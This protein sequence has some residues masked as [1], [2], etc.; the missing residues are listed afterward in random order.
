[1][2]SYDISC[3]LGRCTFFGPSL[4]SPA[5]SSEWHLY[6]L[7]RLASNDPST[8][9]EQDG[10]GNAGADADANMPQPDQATVASAVTSTTAGAVPHQPAVTPPTAFTDMESTNPNTNTLQPGRV[11]VASAVTSMA[12]GAV[13]RQPIIT[14]PAASVDMMPTLVSV[15]PLQPAVTP[16]V[17]LAK[18]NATGNSLPSLDPLP[19]NPR[20]TSLVGGSVGA[21][22]DTPVGMDQD[23][24]DLE[25]PSH[26]DR[27]APS[28]ENDILFTGIDDLPTSATEAGWMKSKKTL[29][30]FRE[31]H[32]VGNL[33]KLIL[34]WY[35]FEEVLGFP[36]TVSNFTTLLTRA[37]SNPEQTPKGFPSQN[38]PEVLSI[39]FKNGH[40]YKRNYG[41]EVEPLAADVMR[42]WEDIKTSV[43]FGGPTGIYTLIVLMSWW[44]SLLKGRPD[45]ELT[46]CLRT[47]EDI[48]G[49]ILSTVH[50][51]NGQPPVT[52]SLIGSSP[53]ASPTPTPHTMR[54]LRGSKRGFSEEVPSRKRLCTG[55]G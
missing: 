22:N 28:R 25:M 20:P 17:V 11:T 21:S 29:K 39:F 35:Q 3:V 50:N 10:E 5:A 7:G 27:G 16:P 14:P 18:T 19:D 49:V 55:S 26:P 45:N 31:A 46:D 4:I 41:L 2:D 24:P 51:L 6:G 54:Q 30:Y 38:R 9:T 32:K 37:S 43:C 13:P 23:F 48:D 42:W 12:A 44:C 33:S 52:P 40:N 36:E 34:H 1:M 8:T 53:T 47:L 15:V